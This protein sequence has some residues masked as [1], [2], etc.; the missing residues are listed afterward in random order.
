MDKTIK[1]PEGMV[2][3]PA[4][5]FIMGEGKEPPNG[6]EH[7]VYLD[8]YF[9][10]KF[11]VTNTEWKAFLDAVKLNRLPDHWNGGAIPEGRESHPVANVYWEDARRYCKWVSQ[12][13]GRDV[14]LATEAEWEKAARGKKGLMYPWG[15]HWNPKN[16]NW[17]G[18]CATKY[19]LRV[20]ADGN[21]PDWQVFAK[22]QKWED[23]KKAGGTTTPV[24][25]F[26][27][28]K[29]PYACYDMA[30]N[31]YE[32]CVD[33]FKAE[34]YRSSPGKNPTGPSEEE[35]EIVP[36]HNAK[37]RVMRGG[38]WHSFPTNLRCTDRLYYG[39]ATKHPYIGFRLVVS[40]E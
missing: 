22:T 1:V 27:Q 33:W 7:K 15:N 37:V 25:S 32:W 18:L 31:V 21:I 34:Y 17:V 36:S 4:G 26:E 9:I 11:E 13:T 6:P 14:H 16:C 24:G 35:A 8:A 10:G 12:E 19:G 40:A 3:V 39:T 5:E 20:N 29:S 30:G 28:G 2:Y 38:A 23:V